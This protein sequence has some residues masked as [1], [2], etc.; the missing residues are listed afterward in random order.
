MSVS[1]VLKLDG[2]SMIS[3]IERFESVPMSHSMRRSALKDPLV[4]L[5]F[6]TPFQCTHQKLGISHLLISNQAFQPIYS[7]DN[8]SD[9]FLTSSMNGTAYEIIE[10]SEDESSESTSEEENTPEFIQPATKRK[11]PT[12]TQDDSPITN[13]IVPPG[14]EFLYRDPIQPSPQ[15]HS[16]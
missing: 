4:T 15:R 5:I 2:W 6:P 16:S 9:G 1:L 7:E 10:L 12:T 14:D 13:R 3:A 8:L 11:V